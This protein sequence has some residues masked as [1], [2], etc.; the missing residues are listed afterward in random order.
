ML[1]K[2]KPFNSDIKVEYNTNS[3]FVVDTK[4]RNIKDI[5]SCNSIFE[6]MTFLQFTQIF[7]IP[8]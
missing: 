4:K 1:Y 3:F 8:R 6:H 2:L 5:S 7:S